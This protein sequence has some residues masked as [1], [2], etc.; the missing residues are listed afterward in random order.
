M[1]GGG[2]RTGFFKAHRGPVSAPGP[3]SGPP[4]TVSGGVDRGPPVLLLRYG[5]HVGWRGPRPS[6]ILGAQ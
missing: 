5:G 3:T 6:S 2:V 1:R 4:F